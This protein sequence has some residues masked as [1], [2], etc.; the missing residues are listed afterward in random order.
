M[1]TQ[2][3]TGLPDVVL[4]LIEKA[5]GPVADVVP[6][7]AGRNSVIAARVRTETCQSDQGR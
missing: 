6:V 7:N 2:R 3:L 4:R 1:P 5:S